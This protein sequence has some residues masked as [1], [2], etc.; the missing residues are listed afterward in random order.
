MEPLG[1]SGR[2]RGRPAL[3]YLFL[4]HVKD[5]IAKD[6]AEALKVK[7]VPKITSKGY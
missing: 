1:S 6:I 4:L 2:E 7:L 3:G 5:Q